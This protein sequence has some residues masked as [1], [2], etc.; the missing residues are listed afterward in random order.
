MKY[1]PRVVSGAKGNAEKVFRPDLCA[2]S[3]SDSGGGG[4]GGAR[5]S[6]ASKEGTRFHALKRF[7]E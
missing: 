6:L 5:P 2:L 1:F 4:G 3:G 7:T